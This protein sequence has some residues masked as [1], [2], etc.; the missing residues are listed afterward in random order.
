MCDSAA[1]SIHDFYP[2]DR[3]RAD[4]AGIQISAFLYLSL[5]GIILFLWWLYDKKQDEERDLLMDVTRCI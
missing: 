3:T 1:K 5:V 4:S 2:W